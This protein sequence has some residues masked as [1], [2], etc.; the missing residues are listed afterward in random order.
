ML[1]YDL[2]CDASID[3]EE[4]VACAGCTVTRNGYEATSY[5]II[6]KEATNNSAEILAIWLGVR[7]A[8][9]IRNS[10]MQS[11]EIQRVKFRLFSDSKISLF[12]V[13]TWIFSWIRRQKEDGTLINSTEQP[14]VNQEY[15]ADIYKSIVDNELHI[16]FYHQRGHVC[17][18]DSSKLEKA[19]KDFRNANH[20]PLHRLGLDITHISKYN[21]I[22]DNVT[23][24]VVHQYVH[25]GYE[26]FRNSNFVEELPFPLKY[27]ACP[28]DMMVYRKCI[29]NGTNVID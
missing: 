7:L 9:G 6:Q 2:F 1:V 15:F 18:F 23:R 25:T 16:E 17:I 10:I 8:I 4:H 20:V 11:K 24:D 22:V 19:A 14:V 13:K 28:R 5:G 21:D 26:P 12:G 27:C 3:L 29:S